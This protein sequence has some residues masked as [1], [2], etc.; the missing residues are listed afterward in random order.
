L[1]GW[2]AGAAGDAA[3]ICFDAWLDGRGGARN[4]ERAAILHAVR[5]F[6]ERHGESRFQPMHAR[7]YDRTINNRAGFYDKHATADDGTVFYV[8]PSTFTGEMCKGKPSR[9]VAKVLIAEG[10]LLP[11]ERG[12][13]SSRFETLPGMGQVRCYVFGPKATQA[14]IL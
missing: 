2:A 1:T 14:E 13:K 9:S 5:D 10:W 7:D 11:D 4:Q 6:L 3:K 12:G 8:L